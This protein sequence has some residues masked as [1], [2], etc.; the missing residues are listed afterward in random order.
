MEKIKKMYIANLAFVLDYTDGTTNDEIE[1]E[2]FRI[3]FQN[4]GLTPYD[5]ANGGNFE[6]IE[7]SAYNQVLVM[8]FF[9]DL[10]ES[11]YRLNETREFNPYIVVGYT[12]IEITEETIQEKRVH[13]FN[14]AYRL[15]QDLELQGKIKT[16]IG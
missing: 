15:L 4:K 16:E 10:I 14:M 1:S 6:Q 7:Q 3:A 13:Y 2:L 11:I 5:R 12:D 9:K 8:L